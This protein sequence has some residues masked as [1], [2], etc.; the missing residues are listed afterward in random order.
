ML[1]NIPACQPGVG[2]VIYAPSQAFQAGE[3]AERLNLKYG[4][5]TVGFLQI[6]AGNLWPQM[7]ARTKNPAVRRLRGIVSQIDTCT[8]RIER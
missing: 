4:I 8:L 2:F 6:V 3:Q 7:N 5:L 1:Q